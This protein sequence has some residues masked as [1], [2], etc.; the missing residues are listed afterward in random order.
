MKF[1]VTKF[2]VSAWMAHDSSC[3]TWS[4]FHHDIKSVWQLLGTV[5]T[6][7]IDNTF[8]FVHIAFGSESQGYLNCD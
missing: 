4:I 5:P 8:D 1:L 6:Y 2:N 7:N 3:T